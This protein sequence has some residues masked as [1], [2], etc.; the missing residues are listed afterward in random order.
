MSGQFIKGYIL[1]SRYKVLSSPMRGGYGEVLICFDQD[2]ELIIAAKTIRE[3]HLRNKNIIDQFYNESIIWINL[4]FHPHIVQALGFE[5]I[6]G[7]PFLFMEFIRGIADKKSPSLHNLI[8]TPISDTKTTLTWGI[9]ICEAMEHVVGIFPDFLHGDLTPNNILVDYHQNAKLSDFGLSR[10]KNQFVSSRIDYNAGSTVF[11]KDIE[12]LSNIA[13]LGVYLY[14]APERILS[15]EFDI[16]ADVYS[17]GCILYELIAK[18][19]IFP[20]ASPREYLKHHTSKSPIPLKNVT[21]ISDSLNNLVMRCLNKNPSDRYTN[22][23]QLRIDLIKCYSDY[24]DEEY[25]SIDFS[26]QQYE[27]EE[28]IFKAYSLHQVG[29]P[30]EAIK[31]CKKVLEKDPTNSAALI[32]IVNSLSLTKNSEEIEEYADRAVKTSPS[33]SKSWIAKAQALS[34]A[35]YSDPNSLKLVE[36]AYDTAID[37][38]ETSFLKSAS[39]FNKAEFLQS[40]GDYI[41]AIELLRKASEITPNDDDI[42]RKKGEI[43]LKIENYQDAY[44]SFERALRINQFD[45]RSWHWSGL[46]LQL[47]GQYD[48]ALKYYDKALGLNPIY[49]D[50]LA[51]KA[52]LLADLNRKEE[53]VLYYDK[54]LQELQRIGMESSIVDSEESLFQQ[55]RRGELVSRSGFLIYNRA[56]TLLELGKYEEACKGFEDSLNNIILDTSAEISAIQYK[57]T[58]EILMNKI[59]KAKETISGLKYDQKESEKWH[60]ILSTIIEEKDH[61]KRQS[62]CRAVLYP[63][64]DDFTKNHQVSIPLLLFRR[65]SNAVGAIMTGRIETAKDLISKLRYNHIGAEEWEKRLTAIIEEKDISKRQYKYYAEIYTLAY[66][67]VSYR[68]VCLPLL[69]FRKINKEYPNS[70]ISEMIKTGLPKFEEMYRNNITKIPIRA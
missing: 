58:A 37:L 59:E 20:E 55:D 53:A 8:N 64:A 1:G 56:F 25:R 22:F 5:T 50:S 47:A 46:I 38:A 65:I 48:S 54:I 24:S 33:C 49:V 39:L 32:N 23:K 7:R 40:V 18:N 12:K 44:D 67:L 45:V 69:I 27:I 29:R 57:A 2:E 16:K 3:D 43:Y 41:N 70:D 51:N 21:D 26:N 60:K 35:V 11:S 9:Q 28:M 30:I 52:N 68:Q 14:L 34:R 36:A 15:S 17:F 61:Q 19:V 31:W 10:I 13:E 42:W 6:E 66:E 4:G 63:F 62:K